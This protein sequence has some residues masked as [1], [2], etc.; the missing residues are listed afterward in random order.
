MNTQP[1]RASLV[2]AGITGLVIGPHL[3]GKQ[4]F[5]KCDCLLLPCS[6]ITTVTNNMMAMSFP[7]NSRPGDGWVN[8]P[9]F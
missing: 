5:L 2:S 6:E 8:R 3:K 7:M 9:S 4:M 1:P